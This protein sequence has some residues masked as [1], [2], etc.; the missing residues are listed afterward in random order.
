MAIFR[1]IVNIFG[2]IA[3]AFVTHETRKKAEHVARLERDLA[4]DLEKR[5]RLPPASVVVSS[6]PVPRIE[7]KVPVSPSQ[8]AQVE[9]LLDGSP[10]VNV[11][12]RQGAS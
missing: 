10:R 5:L 12:R 9:R 8:L 7:L 2:K 6:S 3:L 4:S 11:R 1:G